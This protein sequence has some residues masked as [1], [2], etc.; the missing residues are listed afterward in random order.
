MRHRAT[1]VTAV[2]DRLP[3]SD[4]RHCR[5]TLDAVVDHRHGYNSNLGLRRRTSRVIAIRQDSPCI[6]HLMFV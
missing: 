2:R 1:T 3:S 5:R 6:I 4:V